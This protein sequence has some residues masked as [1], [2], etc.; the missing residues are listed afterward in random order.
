LPST[1]LRMLLVV[2]ALGVSAMP[3]CG[4]SL[5]QMRPLG[6]NVTNDRGKALATSEQRMSRVAVQPA[7]GSYDRKARAEFWIFAENLGDRAVDF[8]ESDIK[9]EIDGEPAAVLTA[10]DLRQEAA[11]D[12]DDARRS[13]RIAAA[14]RGMAATNAGTQ[15]STTT[16]YSPRGTTTI[17]STTTDPAAAQAAQRDNVRVRDAQLARAD[18]TEHQA[19]SRIAETALARTTL[20]PGQ[21]LTGFI[22]VE[23]PLL[24]DPFN[25]VCKVQLRASVGTDVHTFLFEQ[26]SQE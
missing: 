10:D 16:I 11:E 18:A 3:G 19:L 17:Q 7:V 1:L 5:V 14:F 15:H 22:A 12:A 26:R 25:D 21:A 23:S 8:S 9:V 4:V 20:L 6:D 13:A 2:L 24:E